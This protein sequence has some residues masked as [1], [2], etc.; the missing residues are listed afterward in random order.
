MTEITEREHF[1]EERVAEL[2]LLI[3]QHLGRDFD[4]RRRADIERIRTASAQEQFDVLSAA[5]QSAIGAEAY[6]ERYTCLL[7]R[8]VAEIDR[9]LG[10]ADFKR[11]FGGPPEDALGIVD[12]DAYARAQRSQ[13]IMRP[14]REL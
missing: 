12:R 1:A 7:Q 11:V 2:V 6:L 4:R 8:T 3:E 10:R 14:L 9:V 13:F 5:E